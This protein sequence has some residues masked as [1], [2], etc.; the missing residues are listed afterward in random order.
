MKTTQK[1]AVNAYNALTE[2]GKQPFPI[3][4]ALNLMILRKKLET[5][6]EFQMQEE[7]KL[8]DEY[9][10]TIEGGKISMPYDKK[11][12]AVKERAKEFFQKLSNLNKMEI[13]VDADPAPVNIPDNVEIKPETLLALDGFVDWRN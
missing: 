4:D 2:I 9:H 11:D 10:P 13:E 7:Q 12:E 5:A 3:R 6:M 1:A 8:V